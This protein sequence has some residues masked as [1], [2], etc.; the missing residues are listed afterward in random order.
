MLK[1]L[2]L[3]I[4]IFIVEK[5]QIM[6]NRESILQKTFLIYNRSKIYINERRFAKNLILHKK[7]YHFI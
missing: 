1:K 6:K 5:K 2:I 7:N 3:T 4:N